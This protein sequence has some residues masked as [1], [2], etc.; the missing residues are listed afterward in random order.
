LIDR[1]PHLIWQLL[2]KRPHRFERYLPAGSFRYGN[3]WL[4]VTAE[5]QEFYNVRWPILAAACAEHDCLPWISYE[6]ALGPLTLL[7]F[8]VWPRWIIFGG[9]SGA[10]RRP[11]EAQ[12]ARD[13]IAE[14]EMYM[15]GI[16][17]FFFK[18]MSARTPAAGKALIPAD[19]LIQ[20]FPN[21]A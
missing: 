14:I 18:Q 8:P 2:T 10:H 3:V 9:E 7:D 4:G 19:L 16:V 11:C 6:P 20:E 5:N 12:W 17:Q 13:V 21:G 15:P 1:T